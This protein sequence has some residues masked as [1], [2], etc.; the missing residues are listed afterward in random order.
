M[1][2]R[3]KVFREKSLN[4]FIIF[5]NFFFKYS[6]FICKSFA[7]IKWQGVKWQGVKLYDFRNIFFLFFFQ[8]LF[9]KKISLAFEKRIVWR[10]KFKSK[11]VHNSMRSTSKSL[12][13]CSNISNI[14]Y[15]LE[16]ITQVFILVCHVTWHLFYKQEIRKKM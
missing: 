2:I 6:C 4:Y 10:L 11:Q 1:T 8:I 15:Y 3:D 12:F 5:S 7:W 14:Y 9:I 16:N 13:K